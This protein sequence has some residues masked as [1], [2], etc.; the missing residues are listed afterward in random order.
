MGFT[1]N[2]VEEVKTRWTGLTRENVGLVA[3]VLWNKFGSLAYT[4]EDKACELLNDFRDSLPLR[5][6]NKKYDVGL[7]DDILVETESVENPG[8]PKELTPW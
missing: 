3:D 2:I 1:M 4:D 6:I 5:D 8:P 7:S